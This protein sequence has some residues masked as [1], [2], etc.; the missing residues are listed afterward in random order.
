MA[1]GVINKMSKRKITPHKGGRSIDRHARVTPEI[2]EMLRELWQRHRISL[3]DIL[4]P[5][6]KAKYAEVS[7]ERDKGQ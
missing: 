7:R 5:A 3:N 2:D 4:E 1:D 6:T